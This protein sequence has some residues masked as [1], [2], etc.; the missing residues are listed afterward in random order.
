[1]LEP[2]KR[3]CIDSAACA[4]AAVAVRPPPSAAARRGAGRQRARAM[5]RGAQGHGGQ[6][7]VCGSGSRTSVA[8]VAWTDRRR[9]QL[10]RRAGASCGLVFGQNALSPAGRRLPVPRT[11]SRHC[12]ARRLRTAFRPAPMGRHAGPVGGVVRRR[13]LPGWWRDRR[14]C[15]SRPGAGLCVG[16][17]DRNTGTEA[18]RWCGR[19]CAQAGAASVTRGSGP[20]RHRQQRPWQAGWGGGHGCLSR[21][22]VDRAGISIRR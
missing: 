8:A 21:V 20:Q 15:D 3:A 19:C 17:P 4:A 5:V 13:G 6:R 12:V 16:R 7:A 14:R 1:M 22:H 18:A 11:R 9:C 10:G 2:M